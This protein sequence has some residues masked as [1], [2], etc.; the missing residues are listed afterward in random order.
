MYIDDVYCYTFTTPNTVDTEDKNAIAYVDIFNILNS[1]DVGTIPNEFS[2][3]TNKAN[4]LK[5]ARESMLSD[6]FDEKRGSENPNLF[7]FWD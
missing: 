5:K 7:K 6:F 2:N 4:I 3:F 1:N